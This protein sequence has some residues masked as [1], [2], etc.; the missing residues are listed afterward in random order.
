MSLLDQIFLVGT[1]IVA[2]LALWS[3]RNQ[4]APGRERHPSDYYHGIA[5]VVL[6]LASLLLSIFGWGILGMM[7][8]GTS[9]K[10]VAIVSS[11]IPFAWATGLISKFYPKHEKTFLGV[12]ILGLLLITVSRFIDAPLMARIVYPVFHSTAAIAVIVTPMIAVKK[13]LVNYHF[14][15]ISA[16]GALI[17]AAGI[18]LAFL[19]GGRQLLFFSQ[20]VVLMIFAPLF[21]TTMV[22]YTW[23]LFRGQNS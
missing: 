20:P 11:L 15:T 5:L 19:S 10:L 4:K 9:N 7:G 1:Y 22:L 3:L 17:S 18:S 12:M 23:G 21:F 13:G 8:E 16:G 14:L 2:V 6:G